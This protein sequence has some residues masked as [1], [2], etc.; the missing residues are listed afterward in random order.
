MKA[1]L[2][3]LISFTYL[4]F[5]DEKERFT[6]GTQSTE[7]LAHYQKGWEQILDR[8]EWTLA[9]ASFRKAVE[10]DSGFLL[11]WSQVGRI[12]KNPEERTRIFTQLSAQKSMIRDWEK[13]LLE[14][15]LGSLELID[16]KD[17]GVAISPEQ[18]R[19]FYQLSERNFSG[20]LQVFPD[21]RYVQSEYIEVIH[22]IYGAEAGL[23]SLK[24]LNQAE[25]KLNPFLISYTAQMQAELKEF[26]H[27]FQTARELEK[28]LNDSSL[29]IIPF[30]YAFIQ[31]EKGEFAEAE[32]LLGQTLALDKN[33][34]LAQRLKK[35]VEEKLGGF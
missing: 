23:D 32:K 6:Y 11:G 1:S 4:F 31:F 29:P 33:H 22:G 5:P 12:S 28:M 15:Y 27:A 10:L 7:A 25:N 18:V 14:V 3:W 21:E 20:F 2:L 16:S 35:R 8:G 34:T 13:K 24:K 26:E 19:N 30:T 9:E 17:R